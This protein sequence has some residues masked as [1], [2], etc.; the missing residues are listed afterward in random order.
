MSTKVAGMATADGYMGQPKWYLA[1]EFR[2]KPPLT[3]Q[4]AVFHVSQTPDP[5]HLVL[6]EITCADQKAAERRKRDYEEWYR[7]G[8]HLTRYSPDSLFAHIVKN[9]LTLGVIRDVDT[10]TVPAED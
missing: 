5:R 8:W 7:R 10:D 4:N 3:P 1:L 6:V 2:G 9:Y